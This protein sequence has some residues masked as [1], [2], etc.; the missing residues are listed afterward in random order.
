MNIAF[1]ETKDWEAEYIKQK[2]T[3]HELSFYQTPLNKLNLQAQDAEVLAPFV[4]CELSQEVLENYKNLK[5]IATR[6]TGYDHIDVKYCQKKGIKVSFVPTYGENTVAEFAF[7]LMLTLSRNLYQ[8]IKRVKEEGDFNC[9]GLTGFD[10]KGK[11]LGVV[12]TG[13]IGVHV[14]KIAF[15][16]DMKIL[17]YDPHPNQ[18]LVKQYNVQYLDLPELLKQS[19]IITLHVPY[20]AV[21]PSFNKPGEY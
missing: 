21:H 4:G 9:E 5:F 6:S 11:A 19:D 16:F 10:L 2:F 1:F 13:H 12:G 18:E 15:G 7:G 14:I 3:G 8:A 20:F 17:A